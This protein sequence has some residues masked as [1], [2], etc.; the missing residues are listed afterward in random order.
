MITGAKDVNL[1]ICMIDKE[2]KIIKCGYEYFIGMLLV[3][4]DQLGLEV[5]R[6][7]KIYKNRCKNHLSV[8]KILK[9]VSPYILNWHPITKE[10]ELTFEKE[11]VLAYTGV[12]N[13]GDMIEIQCNHI[14]EFG[15][16]ILKGIELADLDVDEQAFVI[17]GE[18]DPD[19]KMFKISEQKQKHMK[20]YT[21]INRRKS[22]IT[23]KYKKFKPDYKFKQLNII[24]ENGKNIIEGEKTSKNDIDTNI[25]KK[26]ELPKILGPIRPCYKSQIKTH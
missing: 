11:K 5:V 26:K 17:A 10:K 25:T 18:Y 22:V 21:V 3:F 16:G 19:F 8:E 23:P 1:K 15:D 20:K 4:L 13:H 24:E 14:E 6:G 12:Y 2:P 7:F 9:L